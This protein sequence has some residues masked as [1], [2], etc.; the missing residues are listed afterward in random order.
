[1][2]TAQNTEAKNR[3]NLNSQEGFMDSVVEA[4]TL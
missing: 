2:L 3:V 4:R 1:M